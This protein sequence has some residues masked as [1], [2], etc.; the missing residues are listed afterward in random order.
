[1]AG[2]GQEQASSVPATA[3]PIYSRGR[4]VMAQGFDLDGIFRGRS[5]YWSIGKAAKSLDGSKT[6]PAPAGIV[7]KSG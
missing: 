1:M 7:N 6:K 3:S 5:Q 4:E 2:E